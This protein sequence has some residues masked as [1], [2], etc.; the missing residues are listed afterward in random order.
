M[1]LAQDNFKTIVT[2]PWLICSQPN[3]EATLRL[4]CFSYA[5]S[6][7]SIFRSWS[8]QFPSS[9]VE[10]FAVQLPGRESRLKEPLV[11]HLV[12]LIQAIT[13]AMLPYLDRPFALFGH[14]LGA[15]IG[16]EVAR[17]LRQLHCLDPS[18]LIVSGRHAPHLPALT[19]PIHQLPDAEF[20]EQLRRYNGTPENVLQNRELMQL[21]LPILRADFTLNEAYIYTTADPLDCSISAF[22]GLQDQ[23]V[24][25]ASLAA[26]REQTSRHFNLH[27]FSGNHFYL[28]NEQKKLL[29]TISDILQS[30]L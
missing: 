18:H 27:M 2:T 1:P 19:P 20:V 8:T 29:L 13:A 25:Q 12:S 6:G 15:L 22:G 14:S 17:Q 9:H 7:A 21:F 4:F 28:R 3:P 26:W 11:T 23:I 30:K 10:M 24:S 16:F 5:G